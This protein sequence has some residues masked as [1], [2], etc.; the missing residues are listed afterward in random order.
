MSLGARGN[1]LWEAFQAAELVCR[2]DFGRTEARAA[3][4]GGWEAEQSLEAQEGR[5]MY[6]G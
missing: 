4:E 6:T 2:F 5:R 1:L 3:G